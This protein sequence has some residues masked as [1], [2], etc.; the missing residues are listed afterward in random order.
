MNGVNH[1][2]ILARL[3][4]SSFVRF[5]LVGCTAVVIQYLTYGLL[6][7]LVSYNIAY[8]AGYL[9]SFLAN[10]YLTTSFTFR[11][12]RSKRNGVGFASCHVVNYLLQ[13]ALLNVFVWLGFPEIWVPIPVFAIC[14][15]TNFWMVRWVMKR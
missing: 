9:V 7:F 13:M 3:L 1:K 5:A 4:E 15:P 8:T 2:G 12:K 10:Y 6:L 11:T 14:V